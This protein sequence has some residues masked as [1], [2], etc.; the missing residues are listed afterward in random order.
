MTRA[1][2]TYLVL[3]LFDA[4][5][6]LV[7]YELGGINTEANPFMRWVLEDGPG[8]FVAT[9]LTLNFFGGYILWSRW[10][11]GWAKA[12]ARWVLFIYSALALVHI[13]TAVAYALG[14]R[15]PT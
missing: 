11:N 8:L 15:F 4:L 6:T 9:K 14:W 1:I 13:G 12:G 10:E 5:M 2:T 3:G 7:W